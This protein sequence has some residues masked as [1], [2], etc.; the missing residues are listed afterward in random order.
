MLLF[1][2]LSSFPKPDV[3]KSTAKLSC[4]VPQEVHN[5]LCLFRKHGTGGVGALVVRRRDTAVTSVSG[6]KVM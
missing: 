6:H 3:S 4:N 2:C 5:R 1:A